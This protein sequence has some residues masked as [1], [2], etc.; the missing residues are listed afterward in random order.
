MEAALVVCADCGYGWELG[1]RAGSP[2][3]RSGLRGRPLAR[4]S[5]TA[6]QKPQ[7]AIRGIVRTRTGAFRPGSR[8]DL[9][10]DS[11]KFFKEIDRTYPGLIYF[12]RLSWESRFR[13]DFGTVFWVSIFVVKLVMKK[14]KGLMALHV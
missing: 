7:G 1:R 11:F 13:R 6:L 2:I 4:R 10:L 14:K 3:P 5:G 12:F 9:F 8:F